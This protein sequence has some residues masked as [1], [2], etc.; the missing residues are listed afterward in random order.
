MAAKPPGVGKATGM[1]AS[2]VEGGAKKR[3]RLRPAVMVGKDLTTVATG[4]SGGGVTPRTIDMVSSFQPRMVGPGA[5]SGVGKATGIGAS[6]LGGGAKK[7]LR[8]RPAERVGNDL[9]VADAGLSAGGM[10]PKTGRGSKKKMGGGM[11]Q[12]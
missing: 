1:G 12:V 8:L 7:R 11:A 3:L 5:P 9:V 10:Y 4:R 2:R 6:P